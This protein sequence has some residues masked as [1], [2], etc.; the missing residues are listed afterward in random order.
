[1]TRDFT[2][3]ISWSIEDVLSLDSSLTRYEAKQILLI[4]KTA[5]DASVGINWEVLQVHIDLWNEAKE[6]RND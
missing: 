2:I 4:A 1:M 3:T 5:H 6:A